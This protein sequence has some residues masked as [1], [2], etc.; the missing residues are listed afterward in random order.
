MFSSISSSNLL[1]EPGCNGQ[2]VFVPNI[3]IN[4][5]GTFPKILTTNRRRNKST[6]TV[7]VCGRNK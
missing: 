5:Q 6:G 1:G 7:G 4:N 2:T 3:E